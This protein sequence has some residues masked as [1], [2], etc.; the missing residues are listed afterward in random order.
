MVSFEKNLRK[1]SK[2]DRLFCDELIQEIQVNFERK[3]VERS[4]ENYIKG[5][6]NLNY[7][8]KARNNAPEA[9]LLRCLRWK[10]YTA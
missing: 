7:T 5:S 8:P 6:G 10:R 4:F 9:N 3:V 2:L 1:A